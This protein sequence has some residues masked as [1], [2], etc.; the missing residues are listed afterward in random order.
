MGVRRFPARGSVVSRPIFCSPSAATQWMLNTRDRE[1]R[2]MYMPH[3]IHHTM[4]SEDDSRVPSLLQKA[5]GLEH[6]ATMEDSII[7]YVRWYI[8]SKSVDYTRAIKCL[9]SI[10][11]LRGLAKALDQQRVSKNVANI[12]SRLAS[13]QRNKRGQPP[14]SP[15]P[16]AES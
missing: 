4:M 16:P 5:Q 8:D 6:S 10:P 15:S 1:E 13:A 11:W 2:T 3:I 14:R 7:H 9:H 12:G